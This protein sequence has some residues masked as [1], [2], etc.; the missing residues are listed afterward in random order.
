M[1]FLTSGSFSSSSLPATRLG[2]QLFR[3]DC[4]VLFTPNWPFNLITS[5]RVSEPSFENICYLEGLCYHGYCTG[6]HKIKSQVSL[7]SLTRISW[8]QPRFILPYGSRTI[9]VLGPHLPTLPFPAVFRIHVLKTTP[10][11]PLSTSKRIG[12]P[13][14]ESDMLA[15]WG[16]MRCVC[17]QFYHQIA[18]RSQ[19]FWRMIVPWMRD[20]YCQHVWVMDC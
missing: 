13:D 16:L 2:N 1:A 14:F 19:T 5:S 9:S 7:E 11:A 12:F 4:A 15:R 8:K 6:R 10:C 18:I 17:L 3:R 20:V